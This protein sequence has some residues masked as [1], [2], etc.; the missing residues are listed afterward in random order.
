[1]FASIAFTVLA[2]VASA[3]PVTVPVGNSFAAADIV[4][5]TTFAAA[6]QSAGE[7]TYYA[8]GLGACG[9]TNTEDE[10]VVALNVHDWTNEACGQY[11][12]ITDSTT[13]NVQKARIV[14]KCPGCASG[15]LDMTEKLFS[16]LS[17][18]N[19]DQGRFKMTWHYTGEKYPEAAP[20]F[21]TL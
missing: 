20:N 3:A 8:T 18:G 12:E 15:D 1:M 7:A 16:A 17:N 9:W 5:S 14:D 11:V 6:A 4:P 10:M 19:T 13:G 21:P 2:A